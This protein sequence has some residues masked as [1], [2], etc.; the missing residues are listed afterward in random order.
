MSTRTNLILRSNENFWPIVEAWAKKHG[1]K[2]QK[3]S[4]QER[5]YQKGIGFFVAPQM[6]K[7]T[8]DDQSGSLEAWVKFNLL[9]RIM[10]LMLLPREMGIESGGFKGAAPRKIARNAINVLLETLGETKIA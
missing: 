3:S 8:Y 5:L 10:G 6:I 9:T 7:V 1:F 4:K 2:L